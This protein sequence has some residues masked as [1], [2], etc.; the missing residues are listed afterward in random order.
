M[1][2]GNDELPVAATALVV[3]VVA[4]AVALLQITQAI[5]ASARG[6]PNCDEQVIGKW[7]KNAGTKFK[8]YQLR[9][10]VLF[11]APVIFI[12]PFDNKFGP[13]KDEPVENGP[14]KPWNGS[15]MTWSVPGKNGEV[16]NGSGKD[17]E[18]KDEPVKSQL[19]RTMKGTQES[20]DECRVSWDEVTGK[21]PTA[22]DRVHTVENEKATWVALLVAIQKMEKESKHWEMTELELAN[23]PASPPRG[24][25][26]NT[27]STNHLLQLQEKPTL[28]VQMQIKKR[29]FEMNPAIKKPYATTTISHLVQLAAVLGLY[30]KVFDP[31]DNKYRAAGNGYSLMGYRV[32]DFG[33]VFTFENTGSTVNKARRVIPTSE[34][35]ELCFGRV[36][37]LYRERGQKDGQIASEDKDWQNPLYTSSKT[38]PEGPKLEILQLGSGEEIVET[39]TQIGCNV[40]TSNYAKTGGKNK[41]LFPGMPLRE[42]WKGWKANPAP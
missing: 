34:V 39:L 14:A 36:P 20:C 28:T 8:P 23:K 40:N 9:V 3:A 11:E 33:I 26:T 15:V 5:L 6:L 41:H 12:A 21:S 31:D 24:T 4:L 30:W 1:A 22:K 38:G 7:A 16:N 17:G 2:D 18:S 32:T 35:K 13:V 19:P 27:Q 29:S 25:S 37:T 42:I 10:E